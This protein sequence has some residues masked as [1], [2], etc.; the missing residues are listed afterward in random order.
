MILTLKFDKVE[1]Q[2]FESQTTVAGAGACHGLNVLEE[3][4]FPLVDS[5]LT[6]NGDKIFLCRFNMRTR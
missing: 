5:F 2:E 3:A 1:D 6:S 4:T